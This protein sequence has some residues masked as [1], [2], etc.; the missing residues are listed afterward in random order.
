MMET[1]SN[2]LTQLLERDKRRYERRSV[3]LEAIVSCMRTGL[4]GHMSQPVMILNISEGGCMIS[5]PAA[6]E[7][8]DEFHI[9]ISGIA[10]KIGCTVVARSGVQLNVRFTEILPTALIDKVAARGI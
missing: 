10:A 6:E 2:F 9:A 7:L 1:H 3:R 4:R 8:T 5:S